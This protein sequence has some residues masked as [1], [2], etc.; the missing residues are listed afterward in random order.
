MPDSMASGQSSTGLKKIADAETSQLSD[1]SNRRLR[2]R[3][4]D[5]RCPWQHPWCRC[6]AFFPNI[7]D[8]LLPC[9][10]YIESG[11]K[12]EVCWQRKLLVREGPFFLFQLC[13]YA[14]K[15]WETKTFAS[16]GKLFA[17]NKRKQSWTRLIH[18][19]CMYIFI[20]NIRFS[21]ERKIHR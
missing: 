10:C 5:C 11:Q 14:G 21:L 16:A 12:S 7:E 6:P 20:I 9:S 17:L 8:R 2:C 1:C 13:S 3:M 18:I 15:S 4:P 19:A